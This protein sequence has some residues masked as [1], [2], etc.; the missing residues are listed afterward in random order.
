MERGSKN[1]QII[2]KP[3]PVLVGMLIALIPTSILFFLLLYFF[4]FWNLPG[5]PKDYYFPEIP[6]MCL[7]KIK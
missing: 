3:N 4:A 7:E 6:Y 5:L 2:P 1:I